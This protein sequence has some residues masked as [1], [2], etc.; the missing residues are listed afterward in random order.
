MSANELERIRSHVNHDLLKNAFLERLGTVRGTL[1][2]NP[3]KRELIEGAW[4]YL[5]EQ[6]PEE[7]AAFRSVREAISRWEEV[8]EAVT[9][10]FTEAPQKCGYE[11]TPLFKQVA[12]LCCNETDGWLQVLDRFVRDFEALATSSSAEQET[13]LHE[14]WEAADQLHQAISDLRPRYGGEGPRFGDFFQRPGSSLSSSTEK[15][16]MS[17]STP[18]FGSGSRF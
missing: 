18:G 1:Q 6:V 16:D 17:T 13:R 15:L 11:V 5:R 14:L 10:L 9:G 7:E 2:D 4:R 12:E 8:K 3:M